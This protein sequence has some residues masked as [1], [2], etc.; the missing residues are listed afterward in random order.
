VHVVLTGRRCPNE[1]ID[2]ADTVT[3][4]TMVKHAFQTGIPAQ[5]GIED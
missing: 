2:M 3:E 4:M 1:I 5:R